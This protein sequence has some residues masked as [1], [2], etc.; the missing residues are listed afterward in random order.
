MACGRA[1]INH[2]AI[3]GRFGFASLRSVF[4]RQ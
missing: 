2:D 4:Q 3:A 1:G